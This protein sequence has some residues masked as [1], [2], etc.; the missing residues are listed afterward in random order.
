MPPSDSIILLASS[1]RAEKQTDML[2]RTQRKPETHTAFPLECCEIY[3]TS[4]RH[5]GR[6]RQILPPL[7]QLRMVSIAGFKQTRWRHGTPIA[8]MRSVLISDCILN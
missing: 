4:P 6:C 1:L 2:I 5:A 7:Q 3:L 8:A